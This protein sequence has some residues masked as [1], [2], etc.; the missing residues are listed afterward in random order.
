LRDRHS[1]AAYAVSKPSDERRPGR[2]K[3]RRLASPGFS[4][5]APHL[6]PGLNWT[7][8][9]PPAIPGEGG[10]Q[11]PDRALGHGARAY[12]PGAGW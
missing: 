12:D 10:L 2:R 3:P 7:S 4:P 8:P 11:R 5:A 1:R 6:R 9:R